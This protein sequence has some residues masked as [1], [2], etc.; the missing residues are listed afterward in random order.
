MAELRYAAAEF[1]LSFGLVP[2]HLQGEY[3]GV[4][5][6]GQG[7]AASAGPYLLAVLVLG[8]GTNGWIALGVLMVAAGLMVPPAVAWAERTRSHEPE[9]DSA[10]KASA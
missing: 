6:L 8:V 7:L 3:S 10:P 4:F 2:A 9:V 1:E 5:G